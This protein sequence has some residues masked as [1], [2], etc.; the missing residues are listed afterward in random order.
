[1]S[2]P[3]FGL[4]LGLAR[5]D[6]P[7]FAGALQQIED[8]AAQNRGFRAIRRYAICAIANKTPVGLEPACVG[9][10]KP[11]AESQICCTRC[12]R[13]PPPVCG[14]RTTKSADFP[15]FG[16]Y[17]PSS[18]R[19]FSACGT[20]A[21]DWSPFGLSALRAL[22]ADAA[23]VAAGFVRANARAACGSAKCLS[24]ALLLCRRGHIVVTLGVAGLRHG[25]SPLHPDP[26]TVAPILRESKRAR[27]C[28]CGRDP[29][30]PHEKP[31]R[32][33]C[34]WSRRLC[35]AR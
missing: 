11:A 24:P 17:V 21:C 29:Y 25:R 18:R 34:G 30:R 4:Y 2:A 31:P 5:R 19:S 32:P 15:R 9:W 23:L 14:E 16:P 1:M 10:A 22:T 12:R 13:C 35:V 27:S 26:F 7:P 8:S 20:L 33:A 3:L 6:S 28:Y